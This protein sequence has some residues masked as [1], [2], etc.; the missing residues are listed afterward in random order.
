[1]AS[2]PVSPQEKKL[3]TL[4]KI[5]WVCFAGVAIPSI[6]LLLGIFPLVDL[7]AFGNGFSS[8]ALIVAPFILIGIIGVV[9]LVIY[10]IYKYRLEKD[11]DLFL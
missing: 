2:K 3:K 4:S 8:I 6:V 5:L 1:M 9:F 11:D 7:S 10:Q